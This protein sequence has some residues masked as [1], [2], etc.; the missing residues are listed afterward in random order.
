MLFSPTNFCCGDSRSEIVLDVD[1]AVQANESVIGT[2]EIVVPD[3]QI[4]LLL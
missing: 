3:K 1:W 4:S 2:T